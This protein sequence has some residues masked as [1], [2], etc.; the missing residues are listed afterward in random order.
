MSAKVHTWCPNCSA[1]SLRRV[2][3]H[4]REGMACMQPEPLQQGW[5][6]LVGKQ[7]G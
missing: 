2:S 5:H 6:E 4:I 1:T 7:L 3:H